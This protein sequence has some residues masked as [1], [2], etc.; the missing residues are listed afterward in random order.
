[1]MKVSE[2]LTLVDYDAIISICYT[3]IDRYSDSDYYRLYEAAVISPSTPIEEYTIIRQT[4]GNK[5]VA[6]LRV[7][8]TDTLTIIYKA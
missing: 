7:D 1:M 2:I 6:Q 8:M 3:D 5:E 4:Y